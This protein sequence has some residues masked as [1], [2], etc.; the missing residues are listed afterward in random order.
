M[1]DTL[2]IAIPFF[3]LEYDKNIPSL[4][5][6][7]NWWFI[8]GIILLLILWRIILSKYYKQLK[9]KFFTE[10]IKVKVKLGNF[11][12]E[13]EVV[14][15]YQNLF[16]AN[17][18]Y[19]ELVTRKAAIILDEDND[20]I[21][22][23]Y[24]SWY[25]LFSIIRNEIKNLPGEFLKNR[26][27]SQE[28]I[29]LTIRIL[30]DGLRPHLTKHQAKFRKWYD[31]EILKESSLGISPQEIQRNYPKYD[32]LIQ[33]FKEVNAILINYKNELEKLLGIKNEI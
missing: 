10:R 12:I 16:I 14:R 13:K 11:E 28:L 19:I 30:N 23:I 15:N 33:D 18:I 32:Q 24:N 21:I 20:V 7:W 2:N 31:E 9:D 1:N 6:S 8:I 27:S 4:I 5:I 22:E 29:D 25:S 26:E 3:E 17:R